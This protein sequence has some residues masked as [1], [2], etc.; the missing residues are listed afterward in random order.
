MGTEQDILEFLGN[1]DSIAAF[2]DSLS[3]DELVEIDLFNNRILNLQHVDGKYFVPIFDGAFEELNN[4]SSENMIHPDDRGIQAALM[5]HDTLLERL[6]NSS[7]PGVLSA[8]FRYRLQDGGWRWVRQVVIGGCQFGLADGIIRFYVIDIQNRKLRELGL[9]GDGHHSP[10]QRDTLTNLRREKEFFENA[11]K[12]LASRELHGWCFIALDIEQ[13][14]FFNDW[15]GREAGDYV[16]AK[17]GS[18]LA[19]RETENGW[20]AGYLG[21]DDFCILMP[22]SESEVQNLYA[23]VSSIIMETGVSLSFTPLL[24]VCMVEGE[25]DVLDLLDRGKLAVAAAKGD[26]KH[27]IR[28]FSRELYQQTDAEYRLLTEFQKALANGEIFFMLQPQC[29]L[30]TGQIVGAEALARWR[31]PSGRIAQPYEFVP[32][33]EKFNFVTDLDRYL[34]EEVCIYIRKW[35]DEGHTPVPISVNVSRQDVYTLDVPQYFE[36]LVDTYNLPASA[37]KVEITE[38]AYV[39]DSNKVNETAKRLR[40]KGFTVLIDDF[41]SGYSS[42]NMLDSMSVDVVKL[43]MDFLRINH[44]DRRK[45]VRI[46]ESTVSM[47]KSLGLAVITE[48]VEDAEKA[49]FLRSIGCRYVQGYHFYRPMSCDDFERL[50]SNELLIDRSGFRAKPNDEFRMREFLDQNVY[51]DSMLNN[52]LGPVGI[53]AWSDEQVDVLRFNEQFYEELGVSNLEE[54]L[55]NNQ[56]YVDERDVPRYYAMLRKALDDEMNGVTDVIRYRKLDGSPLD[57]LI[58]FYYLGES[59]GKKRFY[60]TVRNITQITEMRDELR[61]MSQ[62]SHTTIAFLRYNETGWSFTLG[63][64]GLE[65]ELGLSRSELEAEL[66]ERS[67]FDRLEGELGQYLRTLSTEPDDELGD[68]SVPIEITA[69][70]GSTIKAILSS[71]EVLDRR[72]MFSYAFILQLR[73][74]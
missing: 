19:K 50:A 15:N 64:H 66:E 36:G 22:Y 67:F 65:S 61:I 52:I 38:S 30:S 49:N 33:L 55:T 57:L 53:Y 70:D 2:L 18:F 11:H 41:G 16:L 46:L 37:I 44:D 54:Y 48:G 40:E 63:V 21:Q 32:V 34:W 72:N 20:L 25:S 39:D 73:N 13:F 14:K 56:N 5:D 8:E 42:L 6:A 35:M 68:F 24:G 58:H 62:I 27:R 23:A 59:D 29:R 45:S 51:S 60:G 12:L 28:Y 71:Y 74:R 7:I 69:T 17:I 3:Y 10:S 4:Y 26:F 43:D 47:A 31:K 9:V 1:P